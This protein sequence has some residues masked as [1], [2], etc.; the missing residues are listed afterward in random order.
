PETSVAPPAARA[1]PATAS[2]ATA[3]AVAVIQRE[4]RMPYLLGALHL[5]GIPATLVNDP[6]RMRCAWTALRVAAGL[7]VV[8]V[9]VERRRQLDRHRALVRVQRVR[10][11]RADVV[12]A[13]RGRAADRD[14]AALQERVRLV[15]RRL[16]A[17]ARR[18]REVEF[19]GEQLAC[20]AADRVVRL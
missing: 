15:H 14:R 8:V 2:A 18:V 5:R 7:A 9:R 10:P 12:D 19:R 3:V 4:R 1:S 20:E 13:G 11:A 6:R 17:R 16:D